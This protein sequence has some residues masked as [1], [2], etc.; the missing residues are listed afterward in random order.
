MKKKMLLTSSRCLLNKTILIWNCLIDDASSDSTLDIFEE[1]EN[2]ILQYPF[3][4]SP[5]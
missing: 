2:N 4:K 3:G 1:F 5:K